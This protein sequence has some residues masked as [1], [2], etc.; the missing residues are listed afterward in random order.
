M[1]A[2]VDKILE[3]YLSRKLMVWIT[4]TIFLS[5]D[6]LSGDEWV[7]IALTYIGSQALVEIAAKWKAAGKNLNQE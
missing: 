5:F 6:K 3:K 7:A 1:K 4:S 2:Q